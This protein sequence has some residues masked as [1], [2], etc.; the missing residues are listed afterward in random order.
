M[1]ARKIY[2]AAWLIVLL[3]GIACAAGDV[4]KSKPFAQWDEKDV[5][6]I[7]SES[8]WS[9]VTQVP[10]SWAAGDSSGSTLPS[11]TQEHSPDGG[12]MGGGKTSGGPPSA[13]QVTQAN[14]VVRW[15]SSRTV[16]EALLRSAVLGGKMKQE[17][18][19]KQAA[20]PVESYQVMVVG[21]DMTPFQGA[22]EK[23]L[24]SRAFLTSKK[25]KQRI[26]ATGVE[27]QRG[28]DGKSVQ[29]LAFNFPK[30][31]AG[32]EPTI[33][34]SEKEVEFSCSAGGANIRTSFDVSKM[35]DSQGRDL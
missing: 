18:A 23:D 6:K 1:T 7:L 33:G 24:A 16:R 28:P 30:Q 32:G 20:Q 11:A 31:A 29:A 4:W 14:F 12:V 5:R 3:A 17:D 2:V 19:E 26:A 8:P 13:P 15:I 35:D 9:K 21:T 25:T 27:F 22:D 10:A 34:T